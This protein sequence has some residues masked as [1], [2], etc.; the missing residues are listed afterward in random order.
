MGFVGFATHPP[1]KP[2]KTRCL[3]SLEWT[4]ADPKVQEICDGLSVCVS[5]YEKVL[6]YLSNRQGDLCHVCLQPSPGWDIGDLRWIGDK[7]VV[8]CGKESCRRDIEIL[9]KLS[10]AIGGD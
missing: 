6:A 4:M 9:D 1:R 7:Q 5:C 10:E 8:C 3:F 2:A